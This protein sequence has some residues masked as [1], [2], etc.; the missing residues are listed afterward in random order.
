M[1]AGLAMLSR[2]SKTNLYESNRIVVQ[3]GESLRARESEGTASKD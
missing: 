3:H 2:P 1:G